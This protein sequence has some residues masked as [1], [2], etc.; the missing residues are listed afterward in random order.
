MFRAVFLDRD[1]TLI[2]NRSATAAGPSP[3][4][5]GDPSLVRLLPGAGAACITMRNLGF[6]LVVVTN[7]GAVAR[8]NC[9]TGD[10]DA[11]NSAMFTML[12]Q[13]GAD[14]D[15]VYFCPYHPAG[16]VAPFN[17]EHHWRKP[18]AGMY[19]AAALD[20]HIDLNN[21]WSIGD[22]ERD[23]RAAIAAGIS[24]DCSIQI[25]GGREVPDLKAAAARIAASLSP[26]QE[27]R[28]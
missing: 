6:L 9:S 8:G 28:A 22:S 10:V 5:L 24:P 13:A 18:A 25:G 3:G 26:A 12:R 19:L 15:A 23:T 2:L 11:V 20:L 14:L 17:V 27:P 4:D 7:Q 1:D 16:R 21:S